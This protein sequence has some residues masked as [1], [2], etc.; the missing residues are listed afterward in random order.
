HGI[1]D[2]IHRDL[3]TSPPQPYFSTNRIIEKDK[4]DNWSIGSL[5]GMAA[6]ENVLMRRGTP[7]WE[8]LD[9]ADIPVWLYRIPANYPPT[10]S[11]HGNVHCL[12]GMGVPDV[13]ASQGTYQYFTSQSRKPSRPG[14]GIKSSLIP[15]RTADEFSG[16]LVGP[17]N[18]NEPVDESTGLP[19]ETKLAFRV[20]RDPV[21]DGAKIVL[22]NQGLAG[23]ITETEVV[24]SLSEW[25]EWTQV[26][27]LMSSV[28]P[29]FSAMARFYLRSVRPELELYV[30]PLNFVPSNPAMVFSEPPSFVKDIAKEIGPFYTQGFAEDFKARDTKV[31]TDE[32]YKIQADL[33]LNERMKL[34]E[35]AL[36]HYEH[37]LL[38]FYFSSSDLQAHIFWW[39]GE[40]PHPLRSWEDAKKYDHVVDEIYIKLDE[41]LGRCLKRLGEDITVI[42]MSDHG[43]GNFGRGFALSTWLRDEGYLAAQYG[44]YV[45][46]DWSRTRAY[47][48]GLNGLYLNMK[49]REPQ[50]I[51]TEG[52]REALLQELCDKLVAVRD[53]DNG[54][55]VISRCYR[56]DQWYHGPETKNAPDIIIG[57]A[58]G[59]RSSWSTA[60]GEFD[61][62]IVVDNKKA[63]SA[64]HC[65]DHE[66][67]PGIVITNK[68]INRDDPALIDLGPTIL[69]EFGI[70]TPQDMTGRSIFGPA[71]K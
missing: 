40:E 6:E 41:T 35:Y 68:P 30:T 26:S 63:W 7:F 21:S 56:T 10:K 16:E 45:D 29:T 24:L 44:L 4:N 48:L 49:G 8:Y 60:L 43:F 42:V 71:P 28:E 61:K 27:F 2:F 12:P 37:G 34:L 1:F 47:G 62:S 14:G 66:L 57:Y 50:G 58:A 25:S 33:V 23:T 54:R 38:F 64:D 3:K 32:E 52:E 11:K 59:Y 69:A 67:V 65:V 17:V 31:L 20:Y 55:Q 53:P 9:R 19:P 36:N 51:V 22:E 13:L 5:F 18:K 46:T 70:E 15:G 39:E